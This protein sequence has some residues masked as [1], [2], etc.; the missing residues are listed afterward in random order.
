VSDAAPKAVEERKSR[1]VSDGPIRG[2]VAGTAEA[3]AAVAEAA[4][5]K[6]VIAYVNTLVA[7]AAFWIA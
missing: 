2:R 1:H 3:A 4:P 5:K 7:S 6:S